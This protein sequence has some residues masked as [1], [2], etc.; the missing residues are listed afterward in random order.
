MAEFDA[1]DGGLY[2]QKAQTMFLS[3]FEEIVHKAK[4]ELIDK[5][6]SYY[7]ADEKVRKYA[8]EAIFLPPEDFT[9]NDDCFPTEHI[10]NFILFYK[11][12]REWIEKYN[13]NAK[14][15]EMHVINLF[16]S[17]HQCP[18]VDKYL[19][20][21]SPLNALFIVGDHW[22]MQNG[23]TMRFECSFPAFRF[24]EVNKSEY[25]KDITEMFNQ[26]LNKYLSEVENFA[27]AN[28]KKNP[29]P[30]KLKE[31]IKWFI[32]Y[33]VK[34][35]TYREIAEIEMAKTRLKTY[36]NLD[37][38]KRDEKGKYEANIIQA[39]HNVA[40][41]LDITLREGSKRGRKRKT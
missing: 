11:S 10:R 20:F 22:K 23:K 21:P 5:P 3:L 28:Y 41:L 7:V 34:R 26:E 12:F 1:K 17:W 8:D 27:K 37:E 29:K 30:K 35:K 36:K 18:S 9:L 4:K 25:K 6:F 32:L 39:V 24:N 19:S 15:L 40:E 33:Q 14:W 38:L 13:L 16:E 31:H 2:Q